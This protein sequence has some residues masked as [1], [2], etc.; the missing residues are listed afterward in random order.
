MSDGRVEE[1]RSCGAV[2]GKRAGSAGG[3]DTASAA[4]EGGVR[5]ALWESEKRGGAVSWGKL[6]LCQ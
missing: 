3:T 1:Q 6:R 2:T 4:A 5:A